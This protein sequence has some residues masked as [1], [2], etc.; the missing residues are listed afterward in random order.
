[1]LALHEHASDQSLYLRFFSLN[2]AHASSYAEQVCLAREGSWSLVAARSSL[3]LGMAT[4]AQTEPGTADV[5]VMVDEHLHSVGIGT[6]LLE[7]LAV[8]CNGN[9]IRRFVADV[10]IENTAMIRVFHDAG[11][12]YLEQM[13]AGVMSLSLDLAQTPGFLSATA[14]RQ[15]LAQA[16]SMAHLLEPNSVAVVGVSGTSGGIGR[17]VVENLLAHGFTGTFHVVGRNLR[18]RGGFAEAGDSL[19]VHKSVEDLPE[20]ID[21]AVVAVPAAHLQDAV[22][23]LARRGT[24]SC[25]VLTAGLAESGPEGRA[26]QDELARRSTEHGM[27]LVG[28]NCLGVLSN[29]RRTRLD[30]TFG[31]ARPVPGRL[32][33]ASQSGGVGVALLEATAA[34]GT[35]VACFVSTGNKADVS[36]NDL[37]MA[38]T[39]DPAIGVAALYLESFKDPQRFARVA[40][41]FGSRKPL[42]A[43]F[44]GRSES[45]QRGGSSHTAAGATPRRA[46]KALFNAAGVIEAAGL[47]D[48]VDSARLLSEQPL[49]AGRRLGVVV[50]AGG[51]GI[52]AGDAAQDA[53]LVVPVLGQATQEALRGLGEGV[54]GTANPVDLGAAASP[55]SYADAVRAVLCDDEVHAVLVVAVGTSVTDVEG[56]APAIRRAVADANDPREPKPVLVVMV[57]APEAP[58]GPEGGTYFDSIDGAVSALAHAADYVDWRAGRGT[59]PDPRLAVPIPPSSTLR[60]Q[61]ATGGARSWMAYDDVQHLLAVHEIPCVPGAVVHT[62]GEALSQARRVGYPVVVKSADP[63]IVHKSDRRLVR[64]GLRTA[65][66]VRAAVGEVHAITGGHAPVLVQQSAAGVEIAVGAFRDERFGPLVMVASGG[67]ALDLWDDQVFLMP[68]LSAEETRAALA[69]LRTWPLLTGFRGAPA[70]DV[71]ALVDLIRRVGEL[72]V[73]HPDLLELDLNPVMVAPDGVCC[74]DVKARAVTP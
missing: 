23:G 73:E 1:M 24:R 7:H 65:A 55:A 58:G 4:A 56:L 43:V 17:A 64:T 39:D 28:P 25:V 5:A 63:E 47:H 71:D 20:G 51:I 10:L 30:A 21:L 12:E 66:A 46:L 16:R 13:S 15:R 67:V 27:R 44:G 26:L 50:N 31:R 19:H 11:F 74:V 38:W 69:R 62:V 32:A 72:A 48:L 18:G 14:G 9:G 36:S 33:I 49:P 6:L 2:R 53:G 40:S 37:L 59:I 42:L 41:T 22:V 8:W 70:A 29:L 35:G 45:G 3:I 52:L 68:P 57:G 54:A 61:G 60:R 34:R